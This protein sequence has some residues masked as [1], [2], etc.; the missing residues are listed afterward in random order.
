MFCSGIKINCTYLR[1]RTIEK[2]QIAATVGR[3][4]RWGMRELDEMTSQ[5]GCDKFKCVSFYLYPHITPVVHPCTIIGTTS[6]VGKHKHVFN[7]WLAS[8][9]NII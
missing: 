8:R 2:T 1:K 3:T 9:P 4:M 6:C 7:I 5:F